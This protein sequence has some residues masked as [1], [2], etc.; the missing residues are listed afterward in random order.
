MEI[1][2]VLIS[3]RLES[4]MLSLKGTDLIIKTLNDAIRGNMSLRRYKSED[5]I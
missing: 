2:V 1:L 5:N 4:V 3:N